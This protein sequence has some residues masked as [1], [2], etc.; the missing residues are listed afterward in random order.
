[1]NDF[2]ITQMER[3]KAGHLEAR[4][5]SN[6][7]VTVVNE[8]AGSWL[9]PRDLNP[10]L[11]WPGAATYKEVLSPFKEALAKKAAKIRRREALSDGL[12]LGAGGSRTP[13][14]HLRSE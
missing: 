14:S 10:H 1:M 13:V 11:N 8:S 9:V 12:E 7:H 4:V 6:G 5:C 2:M 3:N